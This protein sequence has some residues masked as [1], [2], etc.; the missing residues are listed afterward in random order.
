MSAGN[1]SAGNMSAGNI[2]AGNMSAGN[3][4]AGNMS[5]GL[6]LFS[7]QIIIISFSRR[8]LVKI[9]LGPS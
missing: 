1:M 5:T 4:S 7:G 6:C 8:H 9:L 2:S 3:M